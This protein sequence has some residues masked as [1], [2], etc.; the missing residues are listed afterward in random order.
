M[1]E[2]DL[3]LNYPFTY[4]GYG[5][6]KDGKCKVPQWSISLGND[7]RCPNAA[8]VLQS[9]ECGIDSNGDQGWCLRQKCCCAGESF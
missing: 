1:N 4:L 6:D 7:R 8:G 3:Q 5:E 2:F 9:S